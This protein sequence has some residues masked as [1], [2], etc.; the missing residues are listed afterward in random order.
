VGLVN[1]HTTDCAW[2]PG[3]ARRRARPR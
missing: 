3:K 2:Y 1:D